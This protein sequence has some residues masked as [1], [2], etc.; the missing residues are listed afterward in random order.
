M[1][2]KSLEYI[3]GFNGLTDS[4]ASDYLSWKK[5]FGSEKAEEID[6]PKTFKDISFFHKMMLI[7]VLRPDRMT[8]SLRNF[9][10]EKMGKE[11]TEQPPFDINEIY[12]ETTE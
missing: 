6:L 8:Y 10:V 5:W 11:Y 1:D 7:K 3:D 2:C 4:L 9:V 12:A